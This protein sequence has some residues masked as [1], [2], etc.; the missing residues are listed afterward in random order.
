MA[1]Y[2]FLLEPIY[3]EKV[4]G[5]RALERFGRKLPGGPDVGIGE[6]WELAD[7]D[8][9]SPSGG[10]GE[11]AFSRIRNGPL[12][13]RFLRDVVAD[14]GG[15]V[16]GKLRLSLSWE[17]PLLLKYLDARENLSVQVHPSPAYAKAHPEA[18]LKS[19]AWYIVDA[20]PGTVIYKGVR[21]GTTREAFAR[22][23]EDGTVE[24]LLIAVPARPGECHYLP[25]GTCHALGGGIL[26]AE[27]QT[28]SDTTFR[29]F[30]WGR[31]DREL[32]V[33][34][35]LECI[36][37]G[38]TD[39]SA[40]EPGTESVRGS[41][42]AR[43]LVSCEHFDVHH[44]AVPAGSEY[45]VVSDAPVA[46][47][48]LDGVGEVRWGSSGQSRRVTGGDTMLLPAALP[49]ATFVPASQGSGGADLSDPGHGETG[50]E[51]LEITFPEPSEETS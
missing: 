15:K 34:Q 1:L 16:S 41:T 22:A 7:L 45:E 27:I 43:H 23:I 44:L 33:E 3:K 9:T 49:S 18:H 6:S 19:E 46:I 5:G 51:L 12:Q 26:V 28:P 4:W 29:V 21:E 11:G 37:F 36:D 48:M 14:F 35:A 24:E 20:E 38:P 32:H 50:F 2:P 17:F 40:F 39:A 8:T 25:S 31:T 42:R 10:G 47:M 30:D 13:E